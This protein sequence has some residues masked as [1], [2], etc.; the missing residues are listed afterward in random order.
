[1]LKSHFVIAIVDVNYGLLKCPIILGHIAQTL[2][3]AKKNKM[4]GRK[5]IKVLQ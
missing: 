5:A 1:M 4:P 3:Y 2:N